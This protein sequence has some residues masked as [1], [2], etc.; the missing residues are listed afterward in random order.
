MGT[1]N[2]PRLA[3]NPAVRV[4]NVAPENPANTIGASSDFFYPD[5]DWYVAKYM[6]RRE[7]ALKSQFDPLNYLNGE[8]FPFQN[9]PG[10]VYDSATGTY[11]HL[12]KPAAAKPFR[13]L[14]YK[15]NLPNHQ[16]KPVVGV[17]FGFK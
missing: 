16:L 17:P 4:R 3:A 2:N 6:K 13:M 11:A 5:K 8:R 7:N 1:V 15:Y 14:D 12:D 9:R 10:R